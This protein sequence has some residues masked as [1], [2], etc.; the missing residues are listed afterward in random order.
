MEYVA[1]ERRTII[2]N[3]S[4]AIAMSVGG[5]YQPWVLHAVHDW[6]IYHHIL[7]GQTIIIFIAPWF[8]KESSRWLIQKGRIDE[9]MEILKGIAKENGQNVSPMVYDSFKV[10]LERFDMISSLVIKLFFFIRNRQSWNMK[11]E[12]KTK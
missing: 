2:G 8:I 11:K 10:S 5:V 4:L 1:L 9:A 12:K 6:K 7:F 3:L